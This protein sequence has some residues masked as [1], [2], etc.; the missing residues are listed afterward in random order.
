MTTITATIREGRLELPHPIDLPDGTEVKIRL[1]IADEAESESADDGPMT[2][3]EIA[4]ALAAMDKV[5]P[6]EMTEE[7]RALLQA[8]RKER[9]EREKAQFNEHADK[10][11]GMWE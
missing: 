10:L 2:P 6:F 5:Q 11:R 9:K 1:L 4:R 8:E 7:E 3:D